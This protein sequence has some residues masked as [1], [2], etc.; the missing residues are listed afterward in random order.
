[1]LKGIIDFS[2]L[3]GVEPFWTFLLLALLLLLAIVKCVYPWQPKWKS[4]TKKDK[5]GNDV[6]IFYHLND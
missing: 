5:D 6:T 2:Y 1:M 3:L 4:G